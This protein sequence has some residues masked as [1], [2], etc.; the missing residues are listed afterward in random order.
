M[1][2]RLVRWVLLPALLLIGVL[3]LVVNMLAEPS[4]L[5][6]EDF[7]ALPI[8]LPDGGAMPMGELVELMRR[9]EADARL[10]ASVEQI[11]TT[12]V[13]AGTVV[14]TDG[15]GE[16]VEQRVTFRWPPPLDPNDPMSMARWA[17][18][19]GRYD[20]ALA[21]FSAVPEDHEQYGRAQRYLGWELLT[22]THDRPR[23]GLAHIHRALAADPLDG[24][25][26]Q[27]AARIYL[28]AVGVRF[29]PVH[30][31]WIE[32]PKLADG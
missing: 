19:N 30:A 31:K 16:R 25:H 12:E 6:P 26:W 21:L 10:G 24:N 11:E 17:Y 18:D 14:V 15:N 1:L 20:E 32:P 28:R 3:V 13:G 2:K 29:D 4:D 22:K 9:G 8:T 7:A 5:R 27:D 23:A